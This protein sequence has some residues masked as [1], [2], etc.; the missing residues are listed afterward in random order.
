MTR[1]RLGSGGIG[2]APRVSGVV[3]KRNRQS[4]GMPQF[5]TAAFADAAT[6][7]RRRFGRFNLGIVGETGV[8]KSSLVNAVFGEARA[9]VGV[10]LP[11]TRGVNY[12]HE[13]A[14]GIWDFEGFEIGGGAPQ[15]LRENL[16][17][18]AE[19][20]ADEQISV[21]WY[22]VLSSAGRLTRTD[23]AMINELEAAGLPVIIVL[24]KVDW[25]R[26]PVT[27]KMAPSYA[28]ETL[29]QWIENPR[30]EVGRPITIHNRGVVLTSAVNSKGKGV[31]YGLSDLVERTLELSP[32]SEKDAFR[33]VQTL[34]LGWK[35]DMARRDV[36]AATASAAAAAA[37][38]IP[39]ATAAVLAPIQLAMM[40]RVA[41]VYDLELR[42]VFS[43][44]ALAQLATQ[45]TGRALAASLVKF[46]PGAGSVIDAAV[47]SAL[48]AATG[49]G[50]IRF[51]EA[52]YTGKVDLRSAEAVWQR[53]APTAASVFAQWAAA[54]RTKAAR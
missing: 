32:A 37:V 15:L 20:P 6:E 10:G 26:N 30:D 5:A 7:N 11:V 28:A 17:K 42:S 52:I 19:R 24:T 46:I 51:C 35:R 18:I 9:R 1:R 14:L 21:V 31:G 38:P 40:G 54:K 48:T 53:Y 25:D 13:G 36:T 22:C 2:A 23:I 50:W 33:I 16:R 34:N 8:G 45:M 4:T 12:Y 3:V 47:A 43:V 41:V 27:C 44:S 39:I 49:E 29:K